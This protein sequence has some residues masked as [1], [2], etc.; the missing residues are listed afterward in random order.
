MCNTE[1]AGNRYPANVHTY[2]V[3]SGCGRTTG[4]IRMNIVPQKKLKLIE[5]KANKEKYLRLPSP[6]RYPK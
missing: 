5:N 1:I 6:T 3:Y 2:D 4:E